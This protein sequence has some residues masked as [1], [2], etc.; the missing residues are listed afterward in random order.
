LTTFSLLSSLSLSLS[1][2]P[3]PSLP[4]SLS[5]PLPDLAVPSCNSLHLL[6]MIRQLPATTNNH[7]FLLG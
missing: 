5:I 2:S 3:P 6:L 7:Q 1:L 4:L